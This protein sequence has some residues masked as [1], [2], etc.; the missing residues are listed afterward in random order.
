MP[1]RGVQGPCS[2][3]R[4]APPLR[5]WPGAPRWWRRCCPASRDHQYTPARETQKG[6]MFFF[7]SFFFF[8]FPNDRRVSYQAGSL[9]PL[10]LPC[11]LESPDLALHGVSLDLCLVGQRH[12]LL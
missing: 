6:E 12:I 2:R 4:P 7:S 11:V 3:Q 10:C 8:F 1:C 9:R 5:A